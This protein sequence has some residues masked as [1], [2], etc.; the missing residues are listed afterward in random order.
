[1]IEWFD[2]V[3][4]DLAVGPP[5]GPIAIARWRI[6]PKTGATG[7]GI[8]VVSFVRDDVD[9]AARAQYVGNVIQG[10]IPTYLD[11]VVR[12]VAHFVET[13]TPVTR[14]QFGPHPIYSP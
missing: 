4:F 7:F 10:A 1:M 2:D 5:S 9:E 13:G 8:E 14:N 3:G 6:E 11:A 12:G